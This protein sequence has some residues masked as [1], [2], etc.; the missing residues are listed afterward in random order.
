MIVEELSSA[1]R[2]AYLAMPIRESRLVVI[3]HALVHCG[4]VIVYPLKGSMVRGLPSAYSFARLERSRS[5]EHRSL[6]QLHYATGTE[7]DRRDARRSTSC[8][9]SSTPSGLLRNRS[10]RRQTSPRHASAFRRQELRYSRHL[11]LVELHLRLRAP[12]LWKQV[13]SA[14]GARRPSGAA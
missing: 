6:E 11:Q 10:R 7:P 4:S 3:L 12:D 13:P 5:A 14:C 8:S 1:T 2:V 9:D